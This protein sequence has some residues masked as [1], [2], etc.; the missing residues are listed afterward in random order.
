MIYILANTSRYL[1]RTGTKQ[2]SQ[3]CDIESCSLNTVTCH[4]IPKDPQLRG[5]MIEMID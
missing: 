3:R 5:E 1:Y 4:E 2:Q